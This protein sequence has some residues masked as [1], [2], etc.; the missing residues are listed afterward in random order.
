[1]PSAQ[2]PFPDVS[3]ETKPCERKEL[4]TGVVTPD[5][6]ATIATTNAARLEKCANQLDALAKIINEY[7]ETVK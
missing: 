2:V 3:A 6:A 7:V 5:K 1:M 4:A